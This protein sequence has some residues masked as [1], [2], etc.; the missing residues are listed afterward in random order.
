[1]LLIVIIIV[2]YYA[3]EFALELAEVYLAAAAASGVAVGTSA[4][5]TA[6]LSAVVS[7]IISSIVANIGNIIVGIIIKQIIAEIAKN[8]EE[9]ALILTIAFIAYNISTVEGDLTIFDK[10]SAGFSLVAGVTDIAAVR[11]QK[12]QEA[13]QKKSIALDI[14]RE[15]NLRELTEFRELLDSTE[16]DPVDYFIALA[17]RNQ[18]GRSN[19]NPNI[20]SETYIALYGAQISTLPY[21][22]FE[23]STI[24][25]SQ[26]SVDG[27]FV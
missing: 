2:A 15:T 18:S 17:L 24:I 12:L 19:V 21:A 7:T 10:L 3:Y 27:Y 23:F 13:L 4:A 20:N 14:A 16:K 8:N 9:L 22:G 25:Q 1:V 5:I 11:L 26:S 6:G